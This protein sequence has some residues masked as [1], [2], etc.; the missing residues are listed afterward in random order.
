RCGGIMSDIAVVGIGRRFAGEKDSPE[1]FC[2]FVIEKRDAVVEFPETHWDPDFFGLS[3][4]AATDLDPRRRSLLEVTWAAL[5]DAG[6]AGRVDGRAVGVYVSG[7]A[8]AA[9]DL[10]PALTVDTT[11]SSSQTAIHL[12]CRALAE[13]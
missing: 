4:R 10:G 3:R 13:G 11:C 12:A 8:S 9:L 7:S 2:D 6:M 1:S 5:D